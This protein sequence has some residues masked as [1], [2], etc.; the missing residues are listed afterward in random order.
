MPQRGNIRVK[1]WVRAEWR[2][3][4]TPSTNGELAE[5]ASSSGRKLRRAAQTRIARSAPLIPT[6]TC[7]PKELLRQ[8]T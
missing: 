8:T 6:W 3:L 2:P 4:K 1:I 5:S 7:W